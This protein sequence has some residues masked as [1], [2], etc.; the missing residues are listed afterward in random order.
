MAPQFLWHRLT[1]V[2]LLP[3]A[4]GGSC[5]PRHTH[6][7]TYTHSHTCTHKHTLLYTH[8]LPHTHTYMHLFT[9][10]PTHT[11]IH[12]HTCI[13]HPPPRHMHTNTYNWRY[14]VI[15][16]PSSTCTHT[17]THICMHTHTHMPMPTMT[18]Q[19]RSQNPDVGRTSGTPG[20]SEKMCA[21]GATC[22]LPETPPAGLFWEWPP[23]PGSACFVQSITNAEVDPG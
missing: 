21:G 5:A 10:A 12:S 13:P 22:I 6:T 17:C 4:P 20:P 8:P 2:Q 9:H 11:G 7:Q 16:A 19:R 15:Q 3:H 23:L 1:V 14:T 18:G